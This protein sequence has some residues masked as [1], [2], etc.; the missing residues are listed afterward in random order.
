MI[1]RSAARV[2]YTADFR[3]WLKASSAAV[4]PEPND[5]SR[6]LYLIPAYAEPDEAA[7]VVEDVFEMIFEREL[8]AWHPDE[9]AWPD[10]ADFELFRRWFTVES[11]PFVEDIG[12]GE[13][14]EE[15]K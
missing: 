10:T 13:I 9:R 6:T 12:R 15:S 1:N 3:G 2:R 11:L 7:E 4:P 8:R 14:R 5:V